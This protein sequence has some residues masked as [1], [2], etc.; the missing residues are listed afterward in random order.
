MYESLKR[1]TTAFGLWHATGGATDASRDANA[2]VAAVEKEARRCEAAYKR[3]RVP[4]AAGNTQIESALSRASG[5][6]QLA[7]A[8]ASGQWPDGKPLGRGHSAPYLQP[9]YA[10]A[11]A[12]RRKTYEGRPGGGWVQSASGRMLAPDD[13]IRFKV[14]GNPYGLCCVRVMSV[15]SHP[16]FAAMIKKLDR[17]IRAYNTVRITTSGQ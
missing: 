13:Y 11:I 15:T 2:A 16:T 17:N 12:A 6:N 9:A 4:S 14:V 7:R 5:R 3:N 1:P 8:I 10:A